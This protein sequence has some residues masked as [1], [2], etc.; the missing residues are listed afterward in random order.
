VLVFCLFWKPARHLQVPWK[1]VLR[2]GTFRSGQLCLWAVSEV[3]VPFRSLRQPWPT[4]EKTASHV[5]HGVLSGG[6]WFLER[7]L[8]AQ[9][10]EVIK[11]IYLYSE[12]P[13]FQLFNS[14]C[15]FQE[16][17]LLFYSLPPPSGAPPLL[18]GSRTD[19]VSPCSVHLLPY[20]PSSLP[21]MRSFLFHCPSDRLSSAL[22]LFQSQLLGW[23]LPPPLIRS[24]VRCCSSLRAPQTTY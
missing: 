8:S 17:V 1:P 15:H 14:L 9:V 20:P 23:T 10:K 12:L 7:V 5:W 21:V 13:A 11:T 22:P 6:L 19:L 24:R 2:E 4:I 16:S 18:S 3:A